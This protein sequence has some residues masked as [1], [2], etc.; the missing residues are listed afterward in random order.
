MIDRRRA[1]ILELITVEL[2]AFGPVTCCRN[3]PPELLPIVSPSVF[4]SK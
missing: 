1:D 3:S 4:R 2:D